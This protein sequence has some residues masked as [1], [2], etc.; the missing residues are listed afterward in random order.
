[1]NLLVASSVA[2]AMVTGVVA[3]T[4]KEGVGTV[5][6]IKGAARLSTGNDVWQTLKVGM[7]LKP[8]TIVQTASNSVVDIVLGESQAIE[9]KHS[10]GGI[11]YYQPE[12]DRDVVRLFEDTVLAIDKLTTAETG[13]DVVKEVE[14]DLRRGLIFGMARKLSAASHYEIKIP[15][16]VAGIRGTIYMINADGILTVLVGSVVASWAAPDGTV[17]EPVVVTAG[18]QLDM[19]TGELTPLPPV[20]NHNL[21]QIFNETR[22]ASIVPAQSHPG[23]PLVPPVPVPGPPPTPIVPTPVCPVSPTSPIIR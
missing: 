10:V 7:V 18:W 5:V 17:R 20:K 23:L 6:R 1:M 11:L 14:L 22:V 16:G 19:R 4:V 12:T 2:L 21:W 9:Q 15:N 13:V 8:G 3:Q